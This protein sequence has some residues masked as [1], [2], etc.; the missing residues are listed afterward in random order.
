MK[1]LFVIHTPYQLIAAV[2]IIN[3][4]H[5]Y[6]NILLL[7]QPNLVQFIN[8]CKSL[9]NTKVYSE[10]GLFIFYENK[11]KRFISHIKMVVDIFKKKR[12]ISSLSFLSSD[13]SQLFIPSEDIICRIIFYQLNKISTLSQVALYDDGLGTYTMST[14]KHI[15]FLGRIVYKVL[16]NGNLVNQIKMIYCYRPSLLAESVTPIKICKIP[17][18]ESTTDL[19]KDF[20]K[21]KSSPYKDKEVIFFDQGFSYIPEIQKC[22]SLIKQTYSYN[23]VI[24]KKHPRIHSNDGLEFIQ[25]ND[26]L[27]FEAILPN[28]NLERIMLISHSSGACFTPYLMSNK[29]PHIVLLYK[30]ANK[31]GI[32]S[33]INDFFT[34]LHNAISDNHIYIPNSIEEFQLIINDFR[35]K[36]NN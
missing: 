18:L 1:R 10:K 21:D 2:N 12:I 8:I 33:P 22:L 20:A 27:P 15:G 13:I 30:I 29:K 14:F 16:L 7:A 31:G 23:K 34:K 3:S 25:T 4:D 11:N 24:F 9:R 36:I 17:I 32:A 35:N 26:G 19:F 5:S 6:E 28:L